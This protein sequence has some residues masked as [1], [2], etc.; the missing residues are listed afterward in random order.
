MVQTAVAL[1]PGSGH[2]LCGECTERN[3]DIAFSGCGRDNAHVL[4]MQVDPETRFEIASKHASRLAFE[5]SASSGAAGE[6]RDGSLS[7][8]PVRAQETMA[9]ATSSMFPATISWFAAFT[10]WPEPGGPTSTTVV[11]TALRIGCTASKSG[12][13]APT[14]MERV[15]S[16]APGSPPHRRVHDAHSCGLSRV[17]EPGRDIRPDGGHIDVDRPLRRVRVDA[18]LAERHVLHIC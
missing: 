1:R 13:S 2:Q 3:H 12:R 17:V 6:H 14:M 16:M 7:V 5:D 4:V 10:V 15:P 11:P 8:Y 9:P 18:I